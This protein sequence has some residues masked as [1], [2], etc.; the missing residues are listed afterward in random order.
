M[1]SLNL[2]VEIGEE[3]RSDLKSD[4]VKTSYPDLPSAEGD[5]VAHYRFVKLRK[6]YLKKKDTEAYE[7]IKDE[8]PNFKPPS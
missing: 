6:E 7:K 5:W 4:N 2:T 8:Y 1:D 3:I